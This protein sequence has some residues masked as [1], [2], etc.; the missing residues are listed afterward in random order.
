MRPLK[1]VNLA[2]RLLQAACAAAI[3]AMATFLPTAALAHAALK[4]STPAANETMDRLPAEVELH[5]NEPVRLIRATANGDSGA[6]RELDAETSGADVRLRFP[7]W[8][9]RGTLIVS[10]RVASEDG[11]PVG[12]ALVFNVGAP[13]AGLAVAAGE[14]AG[15]SL[16]IAIWLVHTATVLFL[17]FVVGGALFNRWLGAGR[18]LAPG[19][20]TILPPATALLAAGLYLQG[21]DEAGSGLVFTGAEPFRIALQGNAA[22]CASLFFLSFLI[23]ALPFAGRKFAGRI[24]AVTALMLAAS[25]FTFSGHCSLADPR[26]LARTAIFLHSATLLFWI[27]S[28]PPLWRLCRRPLDLRPLVGFSRNIPYAFVTMILAGCV[29]AIAELPALSQILSSLYGR[30]L[31][32]K[33]MFVAALCVLAAYNRF[34]LTGATLAGDAVARGWLRRSI[35]LEIILAV[36]I[37]GAAGLWRFAGPG[38]ADAAEVSALASVHL[39]ADEVMAQLELEAGSNGTAN[40]HVAVMA[41]DF[42]ALDPRQVILRLQNPESAIEPMKFELAKAPEGGWQASGLPVRDPKG[43]LADLEVLIDDFHSVHLEG[44]LSE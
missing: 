29:L 4:S 12:G 28:L 9:I 44:S 19:L 17:A 34:W 25:A 35:V 10:Y 2:A 21:L 43:W 39:H 5:F 16:P 42:G 37:I 1:P 36:A 8:T 38:Q 14:P 24:L 27:G 30:I 23:I 15:L 18:G 6:S 33:I 7:D 26:W 3:I 20:A 40:I 22:I 11:H 41:P 32:V 13:S 31:V